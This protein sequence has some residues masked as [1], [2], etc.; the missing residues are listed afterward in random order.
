MGCN[1]S[2]EDDEGARYLSVTYDGKRPLI[3]APLLQEMELMSSY[4]R[5]LPSDGSEFK[6]QFRTV[7]EITL[8]IR[9]PVSDDQSTEED[10]V[11]RGIFKTGRD[12]FNF[13]SK[14][15]HISTKSFT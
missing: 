15:I 4:G 1:Q 13:I 9:L 11:I 8:D 12:R 3:S 7:A 5:R 10:D 6:S 14:S 2:K